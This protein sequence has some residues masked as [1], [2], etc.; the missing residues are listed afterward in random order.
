MNAHPRCDH[1][2]RATYCYHFRWYISF[3]FTFLF[4]CLCSYEIRLFVRRVRVAVWR[5][6][7]HEVLC[8][9]DS[10]HVYVLISF[11]IVHRTWRRGAF[12]ALVC[13]C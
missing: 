8:L 4:L 5:G 10:G 11:E 9:R 13:T 6:R 7:E 1:N 12:A 3:S 2:K